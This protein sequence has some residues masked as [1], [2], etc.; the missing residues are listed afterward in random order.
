MNRTP[1]QINGL[2]YFT[3]VS[4]MKNAVAWG[5]SETI[6]TYWTFLTS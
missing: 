5:M 2:E 3:Q 4:V 6:C 1:M